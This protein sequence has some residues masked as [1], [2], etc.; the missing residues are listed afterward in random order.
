[1]LLINV[2]TATINNG[3]SGRLIEIR[4][5]LHSSKRFELQIEHLEA[6]TACVLASMDTTIWDAME[7]LSAMDHH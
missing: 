1:M 2:D 3:I 6:R 7:S 5:L 4:V